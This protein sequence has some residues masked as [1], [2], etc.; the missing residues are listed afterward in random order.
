VDWI[1]LAYDSYQWSGV[2]NTVMN[3]RVPLNIGMFLSSCPIGSSLEGV[4]SM[5]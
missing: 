1:D 2:M 4:S 5:K 3:L